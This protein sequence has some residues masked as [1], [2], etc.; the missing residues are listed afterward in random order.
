MS[1]QTRRDWGL[2][3]WNDASPWFCHSASHFRDSIVFLYELDRACTSNSV[4]YTEHFKHVITATI[5]NEE[6]SLVAFVSDSCLYYVWRAFLLVNDILLLSQGSR[7][8]MCILS[9]K[10]KCLFSKHCSFVKVS[11]LIHTGCM[12]DCVW[13]CILFLWWSLFP[14]RRFLHYKMPVCGGSTL[15]LNGMRWVDVIVHDWYR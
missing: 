15:L 5:H 4:K 12:R 2:G 14:L 8:G 9:Y 3:D 10:G 11:I 1:T 13:C 7:T 6:R